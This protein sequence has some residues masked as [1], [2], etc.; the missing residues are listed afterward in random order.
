MFAHENQGY[1]PPRMWHHSAWLASLV[2]N[3]F[4][5]FFEAA[6][7]MQKQY[8]VFMFLGVVQIS[9]CQLFIPFQ[10]IGNTSA[11]IQDI[12]NSVSQPHGDHVQTKSSDIQGWRAVNY[13]YIFL[14]HKLTAL[15]SMTLMLSN[16]NT[17]K[18]NCFSISVYPYQPIYNPYIKPCL[19]MHLRSLQPRDLNPSSNTCL[20]TAAVHN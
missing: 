4:V 12:S 9:R 8:L 5:S 20:K 11:I 3:H 2:S 10:K 1:W 15:H 13:F 18:T 19:R 14:F 16:S 6:N 17:Q 7:L